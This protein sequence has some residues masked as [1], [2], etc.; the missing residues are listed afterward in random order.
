M[1]PA[2]HKPVLSAIILLLLTLGVYTAQAQYC[3]PTYTDE[4][5]VS[6]LHI[7]EVS[8]S[9]GTKTFTN[10][11]GCANNSYADYT[12][13]TMVAA[14][15]A[16]QYFYIRVGLGQN[17]LNQKAIVKV[18]I[19]WNQDGVFDTTS[20][21]QE[22]I[23][24]I[25]NINEHILNTS[26]FAVNDTLI[27]VYVPYTAKDGITRMRVRTGSNGNTPDLGLG[28]CKNSP[29]GETED[30]NF[31]VINPCVKPDTLS[32]PYKTDKE[33]TISWVSK[34][35]VKYYECVI[36]RDISFPPNAI[37]GGITKNISVFVDTLECNT[38]YFVFVRHICDTTGP[39]SNWTRS[40][41]TMIKLQTLPCCSEPNV[42]INSVGATTV[43]FSWPK[44]PAASGYEYVLS[45]SP[46]FPNSG[47]QTTSTSVN[48][49]GLQPKSKYYVYVKSLCSP[50][51][52]Q[53]SKTE[54]TT[55][56]LSV[57]EMNNDN[58]YIHAYPNPAA[59]ILHLDIS[60]EQKNGVVTIS[61]I[62][63]KIVYHQKNISEHMSVSIADWNSGLYIIRYTTDNQ[64][65][66]LKIVKQ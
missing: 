12:S 1:K 55:F 66:V 57:N 64:T 50:V 53:W 7:N 33:A 61:D 59:D 48:A 5:G 22:Y 16:G 32:V 20:T 45:V 51:N 3:N 41:W 60:N 6:G 28:P 40:G 23:R 39:V 15:T 21:S 43:S 11:T 36:K 56:P 13:P 37:S 30:Y 25:A 10:T 9:G 18:Y 34:P 24:P 27:S 58:N 2:L 26:P 44:V 31:E 63:G 46:N 47:A 65:S 42:T 8:T 14:Q 62:S 17:N 29:M 49:P 4:C 38:D 52:S 54:I 35:N 19:D